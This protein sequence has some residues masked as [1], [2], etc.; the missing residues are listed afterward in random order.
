MSTSWDRRSLVDGGTE[1][2]NQ[3]MF[4]VE[5]RARLRQHV[6]ELARGDVRVVAGA[7]VGSLAL[8]GGDRWSDLDLT[9]G[10]SDGVE[11]TEVLDDWTSDLASQ[12]DAVP[13]FDLVTDPAVY[14]VFLLEDY[15][16]LD[17]SVAPASKFRSAS[18]RFK[19]L[20]GEANGP[21]YIHPPSRGEIL[22]WAV[23]WARHGRI[24]IEREHWWQAEYCITHLRYQGMGLASLRHDLP[25]N[26]GKGFDRLP[27]EDGDAFE[28][29]IVRS[30]DRDELSRALSAGIK[31]LLRECE[32]G[33]DE[34]R[35]RQRLRK[36][37]G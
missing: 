11:I 28:E 35:I 2:D 27:D 26:Y 15:L 17:V 33:N 1:A 9:F 21:E 31:G 13:L 8:G 34:E 25:A 36:M 30:L 20:F 3:A 6:L 24:C 29:A 16:Q 19:L 10:I 23:L 5:E 22:G 12:F 14:R 32:L 18:P 4:T 7:E 37:A